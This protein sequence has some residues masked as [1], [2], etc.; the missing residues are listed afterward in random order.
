MSCDPLLFAERLLY[1]LQDGS[2]L[3]KVNI[4]NI[5]DK[6]THQLERITITLP[7]TSLPLPLCPSSGPTHTKMHEKG[8]MLGPASRASWAQPTPKTQNNYFHMSNEWVLR[9]YTGSRFVTC[10]VRQTFP[11]N[12]GFLRLAYEFKA[13]QSNQWSFQQVENCIQMILT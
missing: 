13:T 8:S 3:L 11:S 5:T 4:N 9:K 1:S 7:A 6:C 10:R 12:E 2:C